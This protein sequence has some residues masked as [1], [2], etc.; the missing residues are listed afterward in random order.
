MKRELVEVKGEVLKLRVQP[1]CTEE[2]RDIR[3]K[4]LSDRGIEDQRV[5][6][7]IRASNRTSHG[8]Y[9]SPRIF[10]DLREVGERLRFAGSARERPVPQPRVTSPFF[11]TR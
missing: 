9:G 7:L 10:L 1:R 4:P 6:G 2:E 8:V 3:H 5:L 11:H